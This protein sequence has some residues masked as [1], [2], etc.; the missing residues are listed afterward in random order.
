MKSLLNFLI[1]CLLVLPTSSLSAQLYINE[2]MADNTSTISDEQGSFE[3]WIEIYN[4]GS[5][6]VDLGGYYLSDDL[7]ASNYWQ[8][9]TTNPTL[10][11]IPA[12][13]FLVLWADSDP[14]EGMLHL[15][16]KLSSGGESVV[17]IAPDETSQ[18]DA[19]T[20]AALG[21]NVSFGRTTDGGPAFQEFIS[22]TPGE[23]NGN[24][25]SS[26]FFP[27]T[28]NSQVETI[29]DD[30]IEYGI[31]SG[32]VVIDAFGMSLTESWSNQIIGVRF[33]DID[34]PPGA[35]ITEAHVQFI[36]KN[37]ENSTG[38]SSLHIKSETSGNAAP[39]EET[40]HNLTDRPMSTDSVIWTPDEWKLQNFA[41]LNQKTPNLA[42]V[43]QEAIDAPGWM[44]GNDLALII[45]GTG[46]RS[47]HNFVS[48]FPPTIQIK[49]EIQV[50]TAP[51]SGLLINE[52]ASNGTDYP[53]EHGKFSDW[54]EI[55]NTNDFPVSLGGLF[56]TDDIENLS[57]WQIGATQSLPPNGYATIWADGDPED[58]GFHA[59]FKLK[60][61]GETL[62]L[63][64]A[65]NNEFVIIDSTTY[66]AVPFKASTGRSSDGASDWVIFGAP[67]PLAA[68][69]NALSW[70]APPVLSIGNGVFDTPQTVT[71]THEDP[72]A[73]IYYTT[74]GADPDQNANLYTTAVIVDHTQ[75]LRAIAYKAGAAP[76]QIE[77][78]TYLF[79]A[80]PNLPVLMIT[81]DPD[82][83]FDDEIGI[84]TI[85]TNGT[86]I[87]NNC[88]GNIVANY[89]N[90]W[91]RPVHLTLYDTN[92]ET[93]FA[94][95]G[96]A[97]ISGNCSRRYALKSLNF[98]LRKNQY[99]DDNIGYQLFP[100]REF[101]DYERLRLRNSGQDYRGTMLRD[102]TNQRILGEVMDVEHQSMQPTLVYINGEYWGIQNFRERY[103]TNYFERLDDEV[104][105][106]EID[107]L[108][109]P[110]Y[111]TL[112]DIKEGDNIHYNALYDFMEDNDL[113]L[114]PN[115][116]YIKTQ[117]EIDNFLDYWISMLYV[118]NSDWPAN[119][120]QVWRPRNED[121]RWRYMYVDTDI[122]ANIAGNTSPSGDMWDRIVEVLDPTQNSWPNHMDA[123]LPFRSM[124]ENPAFQDEFIQ[125]SCSFI[126]LA[127]NEERVLP[128]IDAA[129]K[130]IDLEI[131]AH[132]ERWVFDNPF[133]DDYDL[134]RDN[135]S[136]Y[137]NF[138]IDRPPFF[139]QQLEDNF[140][141]GNTYELSFNY[142]EATNGDVFIHWK[143]MDIPY[144]Y[145]G[146]YYA[147][148][149]IR[150]TAVAKKGYVFSHW[151][152]TGDT[153]EVIEFIANEDATLT[154]IFE[155]EE[156]VDPVA[157]NELPEDTVIRLFPNPAKDALYLEV[158]D[159]TGESISIA[160]HNQLGQTV[161]VEK[162]NSLSSVH[163]TALGN[164][165][166]GFYYLELTT[167]DD[168]VK[169]KKFIVRR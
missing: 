44:P 11:T 121:G 33:S 20:F 10:T 126:E 136:K 127:F 14:E 9:P 146:T 167:N 169:T 78:K 63:V 76:S 154:P 43:I 88:P 107:L 113:G 65:L 124:M 79:D 160:I 138:W 40:N 85:G 74:D 115:F 148:L 130:E 4:A 41:G 98:F 70:I 54:I 149:P 155:E 80:S 42:S 125:R 150:A 58:G 152:E 112:V 86:T 56:L 49:A 35:V 3:D 37:P 87:G 166:D 110:R 53:D 39:F 95:N 118:S 59:D 46:E 61:D 157:T 89:W 163:T 6:A 23:S 5:T 34:L 101:E 114:E 15:D 139:Y 168:R 22:T 68:N 164:I 142:D 18:I 50:P 162:V 165:P 137:R 32:G 17:L 25:S 122:T 153:T 77:T 105:G 94:V 21:S 158:P 106:K 140:D 123:T 13:G 134:W 24:G 26:L 52:V 145:T 28:I 116:E 103:N 159:F 51:V 73:T 83:F 99:G 8:I 2:L 38:P 48:G 91:E 129:A 144:N 143:N 131:G 64:Q 75:S 19:I 30:A 16:F 12:G 1:I 57:K 84:Y 161:S 67:T 36:T 109:N 27:V 132:V 31:S 47:A 96:G 119:N 71:I 60:D 55:Y 102:G 100:D 90:D 108:K 133:V 93:A 151:E 45:T 104:E 147:G 66:Q 82:N 135:I 81:T 29:N 128:I 62:L 111:L 72:V 156:V 120:L 97:K 7:E 141:L 92:G 69:A 117:F